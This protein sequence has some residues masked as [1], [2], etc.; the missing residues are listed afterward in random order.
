[1]PGALARLSCRAPEG[2]KSGPQCSA[3]SRPGCSRL[4]GSRAATR[5]RGSRALVGFGALAM[6]LPVPRPPTRPARA[7]AGRLARVPLERSEIEDRP[8]ILLAG[9]GAELRAQ[10][11]EAAQDPLRVRPFG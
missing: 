2:W 6:R 3:S 10:M 4:A 9:G 5:E 8:A 1:M 11:S 7:G